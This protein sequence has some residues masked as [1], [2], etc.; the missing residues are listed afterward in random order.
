MPFGIVCELW[1]EIIS[2]LFV[3]HGGVTCHLRAFFFGSKYEA[4]ILEYAQ[5]PKKGGRR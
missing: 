2:L 5:R 3:L 1:M 4:K